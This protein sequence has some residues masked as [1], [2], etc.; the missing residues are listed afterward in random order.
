MD[1]NRA[2]FMAVLEVESVFLPRFPDGW[3][4]GPF[5]YHIEPL[6]NKPRDRFKTRL[7]RPFVC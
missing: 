1:E 3:L 7:L 4:Q 5:R 6:T 2:N